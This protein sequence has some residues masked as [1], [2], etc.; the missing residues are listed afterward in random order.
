MLWF[1]TELQTELEGYQKLTDIVNTRR[2]DIE[3][4]QYNTFVNVGSGCYAQGVLLSDSIYVHIGLGIHVEMPLDDV[5]DVAG[6]RIDI[7][8]HKL[9][10]LQDDIDKVVADI[11]VVSATKI[12]A[13]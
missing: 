4:K 7:I 3:L 13:I 6:K 1:Q 10:L 2:R 5:V 8:E 11:E 9:A 12:V